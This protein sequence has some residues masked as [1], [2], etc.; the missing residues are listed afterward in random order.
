MYTYVAGWHQA[1]C[2][3]N[4]TTVHGCNYV[5]TV[6]R[7]DQTKCNQTVPLK[8]SPNNTIYLED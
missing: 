6:T 4:L 7:I 1:I 2:N 5:G 3:T 8:V